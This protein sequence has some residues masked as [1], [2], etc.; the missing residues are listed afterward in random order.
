V[1]V[2][3]P[4]RGSGN[5]PLGLPA[6]MQIGLISE[7][8]MDPVQD[9]NFY[10]GEHGPYS[11]RHQYQQH[12]QYYYQ[13]TFPRLDAD[14]FQPQYPQ[15]LHHAPDGGARVLDSSWN[16]ERQESI[17]STSTLGVIQTVSSILFRLASLLTLHRTSPGCCDGAHSAC[18][19][20]TLPGIPLT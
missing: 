14:P 6:D 19:Y 7:Q 16:A 9:F 12:E 5:N 10:S 18:P 1:T 15:W 17:P 20:P 4:G 3:K 13:E 2:P 11:D 8:P